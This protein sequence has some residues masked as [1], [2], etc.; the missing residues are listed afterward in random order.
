MTRIAL[1]APANNVHTHKWL[2]FYDRRGIDV[3][4]ISLEPHRDREGHRWPRVR[5]RYLPMAFGH[6]AAYL[7]TVRRLRALLDAA[8]ADLVHAHYVSS[9][10]LLGALADR[11]PYVISVWGSDIYDFPRAG[12][13]QRH[14]VQFALR[15]A[16][17]VC[18]TSEVMRAETGRYTDKPV[19]VTPFG[20]DTV[21]FVPAPRPADDRVVFGI[22]KTMDDKY[23]IDVLLHAFRRYLDA[24][25]WELAARSELV[26]VGGGPK[27]DAYRALADSLGLSQSVRFTGRIPHAAVPATLAALDVFVVPSVLDSESFGVAAVEAQACGLPVL[28]SD[29]G[30]LPEV[31][32]D[33]ETG[34]V[35][36]RRD[37]EALAT[38][39]LLLAGDPDLRARLG[40][41]GREHAVAAYT[42]DRNAGLMLDVYE[43]L[44]RD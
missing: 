41:A 34:F 33:G 40:A 1:L 42:W 38:R 43:R 18:S 19:A 22:V 29:C 21:R 4:A 3:C 26:V 31:I 37:P 6:K 13:L 17:A 20:V 24:A 15:R 32:R 27:L 36:P 35:V 2:D 39:M 28:V 8:D 14:M 16:D 23:G 10:G 7:L 5:T 30:G 9:Y 12:P 11:H 44:S 25:S